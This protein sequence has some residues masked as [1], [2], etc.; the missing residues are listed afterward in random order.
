MQSIAPKTL[1]KLLTGM[2]RLEVLADDFMRNSNTSMT[3]SMISSS[4]MQWLSTPGALR[5]VASCN[6]QGV[7]TLVWALGKMEVCLLSP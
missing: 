1:G 7:S 6:A 2:A 4:L 3:S 5:A